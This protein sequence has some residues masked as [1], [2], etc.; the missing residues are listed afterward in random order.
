MYKMIMDHYNSYNEDDFYIPDDYI[1][2]SVENDEMS[3]KEAWF[4]QG[5][6]SAY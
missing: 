1:E 4:L 5:W 2:Q 3:P 6:K